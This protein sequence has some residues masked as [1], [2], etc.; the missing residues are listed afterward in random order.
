MAEMREA[1]CLY[2]HLLPAVLK[3]WNRRATFPV[4]D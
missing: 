3:P 2:H 4:L 1:H